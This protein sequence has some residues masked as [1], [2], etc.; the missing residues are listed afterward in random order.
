VLGESKGAK[1]R[2]VLLGLEELDRVCGTAGAS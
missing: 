1:G 2:D